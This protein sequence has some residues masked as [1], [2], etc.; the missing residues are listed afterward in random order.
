M[1]VL[2]YCIAPRHAL[3][4]IPPGAHG[5]EVESFD[6]AGLRCYF[7]SHTEFATSPEALQAAALTYHE[8]V[9]HIFGHE[10]V[11][12][13]RFPALFESAPALRDKVTERAPDYESA[14]A[15]LAGKMQMEVNIQAKTTDLPAESGTEYLRAR[16]TALEETRQIAV[17]ARR[18]VDDLAQDWRE[19]NLNNRLQC[20]ALLARGA[21]NDFL[22]R[23]SAMA[24]PSRVE[25][26][27]VGPW[28]PSEFLDM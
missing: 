9:Q 7:S 11:I 2:A 4:G 25:C 16:Q 21:E 3:Q 17:Q 13:F 22:T 5:A 19:R 20:F 8:V 18:A 10:T 14:L 1:P 26:R 24:V 27:I 15:R 12:P 23:L 28:P 6:S